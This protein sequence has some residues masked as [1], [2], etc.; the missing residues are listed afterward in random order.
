MAGAGVEIKDNRR[1]ARYFAEDS[2]W[3]GLF[4]TIED[5]SDIVITKVGRVNLFAKEQLSILVD[6]EVLQV[7]K[8]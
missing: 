1:P 8:G 5:P 4:D 6:K 7:I 3:P 2:A